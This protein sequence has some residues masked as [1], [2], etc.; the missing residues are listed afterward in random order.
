MWL[1]TNIEL[2]KDGKLYGKTQGKAYRIDPAT[3]TLTQIVRPVSIL[4]KGADDHMY[5]SR[6][7]NFYTY[8]L[9]S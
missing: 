5:L 2:G 9:C 1:D 8:R 7:E 4:L 3:M 6:S